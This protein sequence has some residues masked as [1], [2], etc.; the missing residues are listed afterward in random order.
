V[1]N[2]RPTI[3]LASASTRRAEI[4]TALGLSYVVRPSHVD[5]TRHPGEPAALL[6]ER[7]ARA[8]ALAVAPAR[9]E[10]A[11]AADTE[12]VVDGDVFGKP[13]DRAHAATMLRRLAGREHEVV[14]GVAWLDGGA[15]AFASGVER[16]TVRFA[17][18][19]EQEIEWYAAT[20]EPLDKAG[21]YAIQGRGALFVEGVE[22]NYANVVGLP[23]PLAMRLLRELGHDLLDWLGHGASATW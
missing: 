1:S 15:Q 20:D 5:E 8:K 14:T 21:G 19:S 18:M 13:A 12:V 23:V 17:P 22:G 2:T 7:L 10:L 11:L 16:T 9:G 4:L 6:V 3:V